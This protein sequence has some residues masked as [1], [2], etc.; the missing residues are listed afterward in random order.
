MCIRDR[1]DAALLRGARSGAVDLSAFERGAAIPPGE[2]EVEVVRNG[3]PVGRRRV[4]FDAADGGTPLA[5]VDR[6]LVTWLDVAIARLS[7]DAHAALESDACIS[8]E[9]LHPAA[10]ADFD[11][12][13]LTLHLSIPQALLLRRD[14]AIDPA[15]LDAGISALRVNYAASIVQQAGDPD[16]RHASLHLDAGANAGAWRWR[17]RGTHTWSKLQSRRSQVLASTLERDVARL[18]ARLTFGD[19]F[20]AGVGFDAIALRGVHFRS[21]DRMAPPDATHPAPAIRGTADTDARVQVRQAGLLLLDVPVSP[22]PFVLDDVRPLARGGALQ[23][24]IVESDGRT[25]SFEV[26]WAALPGLLPAGRA[27]FDLAAGTWRAEGHRG[28]APVFQGGMQRGLHDR[29]TLRVAAQLAPDYARPL[30]GAIVA[31]RFG[32]MSIDRAHARSLWRGVRTTGASTR[33]GWST[34][35]T[36]TRTRFDL[37]AWHRADAGHWSLHE[38]MRARR[39]SDTRE[40]RIERERIE[41][42]LHQALGAR[43]H[44]VRLGIVERRFDHGD[45]ARSLQLGYALPAR[46]DGLQLHALLEHARGLDPARGT[47]ITIGASTQ[48]TRATQATLTLAI[49]LQPRAHGLA[50]TSVHDPRAGP[51]RMALQS[52]ASG[53]FGEHARTAWRAGVAKSRGGGAPTIASASL[54]RSGRAGHVASGWSTSSGRHRWSASG[55]G[56][57]VLHAHGLT[58]GPPLGDTAALVRAEHGAGARLL[59]APQVRLDRKGRA[60]AAHLSPYRRNRVGIDPSGAAAGIAFDWTERD[61]VPRAGALVD[62]VLPSAQTATRFV[63]IVHASGTPASFGARIVD[64]SDNARGLVGRDGLTWLDADG[65]RP[66]ALHW[67][68]GEHTRQCALAESSDPKRID[69]DAFSDPSA[70]SDTITTLTCVD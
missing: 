64:A 39:G 18:D 24:Q 49:P 11:I 31:T 10:R 26:P 68:D 43:R 46:T 14:S 53:A 65:D 22:G 1:F 59:H 66:L 30:A 33:L 9:T 47:N 52:D 35:I 60:L 63:R 44:A 7:A 58:L 38:A 48:S 4:R 23:V 42:S 3:A 27:R 34:Q 69:A 2:H 54:A 12:A 25:R 17:H 15:T 55:N 5:C 61:V 67:R 56:S 20:A 29:L 28:D 41:A 62:V 6:S 16:A 50:G 21:D 45:D 40:P 19:L 51:G 37:G 8:V 70:D 36:P 13:A 57:I 32:A